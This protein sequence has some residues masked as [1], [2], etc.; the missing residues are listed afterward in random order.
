M[1]DRVYATTEAKRCYCREYYQR[2]RERIKERNRKYRETHKE[3]ISAYN[4]RYSMTHDRSEYF[5][6]RWRA[7]NGKATPPV[8]EGG[9]ADQKQEI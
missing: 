3:Q 6:E 8:K 7:R 5:R 2:N 1:D 4:K 9:Y